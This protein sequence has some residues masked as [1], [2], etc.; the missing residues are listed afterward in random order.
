MLEQR[1]RGFSKESDELR[2]KLAESEN[3]LGLLAQESERIKNNQQM[4][5]QF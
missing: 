2:R 3:K 1:I 4:S 5:S